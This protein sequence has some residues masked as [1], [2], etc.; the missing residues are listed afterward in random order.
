[1]AQN[2]TK[3]SVSDFEKMF[4]EKITPYVAGEIA[5]SSFV[6]EDM[7]EDENN[8]WLIKIVETLLDP[9]L[10]FSGEHRH[11]QWEK[12]WGENL[13]EY[14]KTGNIE[15]IMPRYFGKYP[16]VKINQRFVKPISK[17]FERDTLSV[18]QDWLFDKYF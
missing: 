9:G 8:K 11:Q 3:L 10:P 7:P 4:G 1:M 18:I 5:D 6:Y 14:T 16:A 17:T 15:L 13:E 12:G 2:V